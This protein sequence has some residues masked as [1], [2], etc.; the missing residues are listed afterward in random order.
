M[1]PFAHVAAS[2][3]PTG[4]MPAM[5]T[6]VTKRSSGAAIERGSTTSSSTFAIAPI[7]ADVSRRIA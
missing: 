5:H 4:Y 2:L 3:M 1:S 6:P 7:A